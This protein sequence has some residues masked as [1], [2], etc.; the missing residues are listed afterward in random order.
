MGYLEKAGSYNLRGPASPNRIDR[1]CHLLTW[2]TLGVG[3]A[4]LTSLAC[5][6]ALSSLPSVR[7][8]ETNVI[9]S[10]QQLMLGRPL[11]T[12][13]AEYPFQIVQYSPFYYCMCA[14]LAKM[15]CLPPDSVQSLYCLSRTLS[16]SLEIG[17]MV[18][19]YCLLRR[20]LCVPR[21][22]S[23]LASMLMYVASSPWHFL[24]RPDALTSLLTLATVFCGLCALRTAK[25]RMHADVWLALSTLCG[26]AALFSKQNGLQ[27]VILLPTFLLLTRQWRQ[28]R[29]V[30]V[31]T[32]VVTAALIAWAPTL[33]GPFMKANIIDGVRNG[34]DLPD[35][36]LKSYHPIFTQWG[37]VLALAAAAVVNLLSSAANRP[38]RFLAHAVLLFF[39]VATTLAVKK[40]STLQYYNDFLTVAIISIAYCFAGHGNVTERPARSATRVRVAVAAYACIFLPTLVAYQFYTCVYKPMHDV[41]PTRMGSLAARRQVVV[42]LRSELQRHPQ[43]WFFSRDPVIDV[44]LPGQAVAPQKEIIEISHRR[45]LVDYAGFAEA[46]RSGRI[47]YAIVERNAKPLPFAGADF[48]AFKHLVDI[49]QYSIYVAPDEGHQ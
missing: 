17:R 3:S 33:W 38:D 49:D 10:I 25:G 20:L 48:A 27:A 30:V 22:P 5:W 43:S 44:C 4:A 11:Y 28:A 37:P 15:I 34:V 8:V 9:F 41:T 32:V 1:Y 45:K 23:L 36:F 6:L 35:A 24:A 46:V 14:S 12:A 19:L 21:G 39:L 29:L 13:P 40:G 7:G 16:I 42:Y 47:R 31:A 26:V 18:L 2:A